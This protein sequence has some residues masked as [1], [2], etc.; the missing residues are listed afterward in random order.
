MTGAEL[1]RRFGGLHRNVVNQWLDTTH[2]Y[3]PHFLV[4]KALRPTLDEIMEDQKRL[5]EEA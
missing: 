3:R 5:E 4:V 2:R 1:A